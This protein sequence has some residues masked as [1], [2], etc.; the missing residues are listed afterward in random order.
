MSDKFEEF[1]T[2]MAEKSDEQQAQILQQQ[3]QI[4]D[5]IETIKQM[6]G[7]NHPVTVQV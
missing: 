1:L 2:K 7:I 5:L 6:P 4:A 3:N